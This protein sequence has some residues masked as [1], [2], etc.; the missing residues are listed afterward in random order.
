MKFNKY[1]LGDVVDIRSSKRVYFKDYVEKGIPFYRSKEI[2]LRSKG[3]NI[4]NP[5]YISQE[6]FDELKNMAFP[7]KMIFY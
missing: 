7:R 5:L 2:I 6:K 4:D 1:I 3:M